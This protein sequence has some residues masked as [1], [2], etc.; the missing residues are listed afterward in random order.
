[1]T[2]QTLAITAATD[3]DECVTVP[4]DIDRLIGHAIEAAGKLAAERCSESQTN[5]H[6]DPTAAGL[7]RDTEPRPVVNARGRVT[8]LWDLA[9]SIDR[10]ARQVNPKAPGMG[11][12]PTS[13]T[14]SLE[15]VAVTLRAHAPHLDDVSD[16]GTADL[17]WL[18]SETAAAAAWLRHWCDGVWAEHKGQPVRPEKLARIVCESCAR[19]GI[20]TDVADGRRRCTRCQDFAGNHKVLPTEAICTEWDRH[21]ARPRITPVMVTAARLTGTKIKGRAIV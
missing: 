14:R 10:A 9:R 2:R 16:Y 7:I 5:G 13:A 21:P 17:T 4:R 1:V 8:E 18:C 3:I 6:A 20:D 19:F 12:R 15:I 11:D